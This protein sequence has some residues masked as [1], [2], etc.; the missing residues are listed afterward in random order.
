MQ[1]EQDRQVFRGPFFQIS[2]P[3]HW[4]AE[5]IENMPAFFDPEGAGV[6]Q[7]AAF[8]REGQDYDLQS[9]LERYL[10]QNDIEADPERMARFQLPSGVAGIAVEYIV[11]NRFWMVNVIGKEQ[12]FLLV[13]YNSDEV[14]D[15]NTAML[16][17]ETLGTIE[18]FE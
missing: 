17:S 1:R 11:D 3:G 12:K 16:I 15:S 14:P 4:E 18:F 6:L 9:E 5:I 10:S 13:L 2:I 8:R 7:V